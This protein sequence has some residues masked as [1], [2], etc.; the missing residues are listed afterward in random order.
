MIGFVL[1]QGPD[2]VKYFAD[3][4]KPLSTGKDFMYI[5]SVSNSSIFQ[6][7][8]LRRG[9]ASLQLLLDD[10]RGHDSSVALLCRLAIKP[11]G[12]CAIIVSIIQHYR[13]VLYPIF[14]L[15]LH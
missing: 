8:S 5:T 11:T 15:R 1:I 6:P 13:S 3:M 12:Y 4:Q 7:T 2:T 9:R 10:H 14:A